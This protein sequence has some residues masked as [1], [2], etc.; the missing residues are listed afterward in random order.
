M[1]Q[2]SL[3]QALRRCQGGPGDLRSRSQ[4]PHADLSVQLPFLARSLCPARSLML[5]SRN[6]VG[7]VIKCSWACSRSP[8]RTSLRQEARCR[9][10][11]REG[12]AAGASFETERGVAGVLVPAPGKAVHASVSSS[13][14]ACSSQNRMSISPHIVTVEVRCSGRACR[15]RGRP[16]AMPSLAM[17]RGVVESRS[18]RGRPQQRAGS[19]IRRRTCPPP[20]SYSKSFP[21]H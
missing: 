1:R 6:I 19:S 5:I 14:A 9:G 17:T 21:A 16:R 7:V 4:A 10:P 2:L 15:G 13:F 3:S 11:A 18:S 20:G 12:Q 8:C